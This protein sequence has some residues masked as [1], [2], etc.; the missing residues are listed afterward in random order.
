M[1][2]NTADAIR[3]AHAS[4]MDLPNMTTT[5]DWSRPIVTNA[6]KPA[7]VTE[8][9]DKRNDRCVEG[10][11]GPNSE[12]ALWMNT[13]GRYWWQ[14][15]DPEHV[16]NATPAEILAYPDVWPEWQ[17]WARENAVMMQGPATYAKANPQPTSNWL[18]PETAIGCTLSCGA[19]VVRA[20]W[21]DEGRVDVDFDRA[22]AGTETEIYEG[23]VFHR[24]GSHAYDRLPDLI[25]AAPTPQPIT[26]AAILAAVE[27]LPEHLDGPAAIADA[28][29]NALGVDV[30][31]KRAPWEVAYFEATGKEP[32]SD[33]EGIVE[34]CVEQID[35]ELPECSS[36]FAGVVRRELH[37]RIMGDK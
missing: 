35:N 31:E 19:K 30:P 34:W 27:R 17:K 14:P 2:N 24:N 15:N 21:G 28:L 7:R 9:P 22:P 18:T 36:E 5:I 25:P 12:T 20:S 10:D 8:G 16:R 4:D 37:R 29:C 33:V 26:H 13:Q 32:D 6:G 11:F 3:A 1:T 23:R